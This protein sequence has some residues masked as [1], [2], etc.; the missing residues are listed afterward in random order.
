MHPTLHSLLATARGREL[1]AA[2]DADRLAAQARPVDPS[3]ITVSRRRVDVAV[4]IRDAFPDD[5]RALQ[6]LAALDSS[7]IPRAPVLVAEVEG[8]L[9]AALSLADGAAVAD[10]FHPTVPLVEL[11]VARR[12]QLIGVGG[13]H[14]RQWARGRLTT[15]WARL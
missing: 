8:E 4:T 3:I 11:L 7:E 9:R 5:A 1:R 2:A 15:R 10:P 6:R 13:V 14:R 12:Q